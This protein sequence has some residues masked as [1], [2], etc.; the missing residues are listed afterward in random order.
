MHPGP[1]LPAA[2]RDNVI[3][4]SHVKGLPNMDHLPSKQ[5]KV[6]LDPND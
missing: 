5:M 6:L 1:D 3:K 4:A 2:L